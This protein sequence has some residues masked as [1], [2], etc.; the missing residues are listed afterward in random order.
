[1]FDLLELD[2]S[3]WR[4]D[5]EP[6]TPT[7][8]FYAVLG[9]PIAHSLSPAMHNAALREREI[10]AEYLPLR[11]TAA[12]LPLLKDRVFGKHLVG[13]NV[14]APH[15]AAV[16][17]MCEGRTEQA[18]DLGVVNTVKISDGHWFG[19]NTDSGGIMSVVS[20][21]WRDG[22]R[23]EQVFVL[24]A[25]GSARAALDAMLRWGVPQLEVRDRSAE[26]RGRIRSW[27]E[28]RAV[29]DEVRV[30]ELTPAETKAGDE[31]SLWLCCLAGG[32]P[33]LPYLPVAA[34]QRQ[35][36]LLDLRYGN[37]RSVE[38]APLGFEFSDGLPILLVQGGLSF[39]WWCG[40][41]VP[42]SR[43]RDALQSR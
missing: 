41:P 11:I 36:V 42:W 17:A 22:E 28:G 7:R 33:C 12:Q 29:G 34:G 8:P 32:V 25:G 4:R 5:G 2:D 14:T 40:L 13:F 20:Q 6:W 21:I 35:T 30:T 15:K 19:H 10:D 24:G 9:D 27:L 16:A 31:S 1:M 43:M 3:G 37:Q 38:E 39:A 18:R 26:G 23:P